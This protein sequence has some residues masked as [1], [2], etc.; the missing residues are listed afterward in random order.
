M[1]VDRLLAIGKELGCAGDELKTRVERE[2]NLQ[3]EE[4]AQAL[5]A[6]QREA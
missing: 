3:G 1:K 5:E 2:T 6:A 4:R